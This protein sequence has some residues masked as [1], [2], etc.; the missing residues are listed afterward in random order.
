MKT[1]GA[2]HRRVIAPG[3][4]CPDD[5]PAVIHLLIEP[6]DIPRRVV[7]DDEDDFRAVT[8][9]GIDLHRIDAER[10]VAAHHDHLLLRT[11]KARC[12]PVRRS[13]T[14]TTESARIEV[15]ARRLET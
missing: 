14:E 7:G 11:Q 5:A 8:L 1:E 4:R 9:R 10:S 2:R 6:L 12:D 3:K 15:S 13:D